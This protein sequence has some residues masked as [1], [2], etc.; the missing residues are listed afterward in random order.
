MN[1]SV[2][3]LETG[4]T[5]RGFE[6]FGREAQVPVAQPVEHPALIVRHELQHHQ[7]SPGLEQ[8]PGLGQH[9]GGGLHVVQALGD[10]D[11]IPL[12]GRQR[13]AVQV[14][15]QELDV[16]AALARGP[17]LRLRERLRVLID[18]PHP[19]GPAGNGHREGAGATT[20]VRHIEGRQQR[21]QRA[22]PQGPGLA[23]LEQP[24][25]ERLP[26]LPGAEQILQ[27]GGVSRVVLGLLRQADE[28]PAAVGLLQGEGVV[29]EARLPLLADKAQPLELAQVVGHRGLG[30]AHQGH[31]FRHVQRSLGHEA[32]DPQPCRVSKDA[33]GLGEDIHIGEST[34]ID[35]RDDTT[36]IRDAARCPPG[37]TR[38]CGRHGLP[39]LAPTPRRQTHRARP[40]RGL[41]R[42]LRSRRLPEGPGQRGA[43]AGGL[44]GHLGGRHGG[45]ARRGGHADSRDGGVAAEADAGE[46]LGSRP[47]GGGE[48]RAKG[49]WL[50]GPAQGPAVPDAAGGQP[51]GAH[52]RGVAAPAALGGREPHPGHAR[53]VH[54]GRAGTGHP[55]HLCLPGAVPL[56][57]HR[58]VALLGRRPGG[59]GACPGAERERDRQGPGRPPRALPPEQD[60]QG[61]GRPLGVR[62]GIGDGLLG[63]AARPLPASAEPVG[64]AE[65]ARV[66]RHLQPAP[67]DSD[68]PGARLRRHGSSP[69]VRGARPGAAAP[70]VRSLMSGGLSGS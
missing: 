21:G 14:L 19:A 51:A 23:R 22:R 63:P 27:P 67:C 37:D 70:E 65:G 46:L 56:G 59:Q 17:L 58:P 53:C 38:L 55:R 39:H 45:G 54:L 10:D 1:L 12:A 13:Q 43:P 8:P 31:Q 7:L 28:R 66:R 4:L 30:H 57:A 48:G 32:Q 42:F 62:P 49:A 68:H 3:E 44:R 41:F 61:G 35:S 69:A 52:L 15:A 9:R 26:V 18:G 24:L 36:R 20:E 47:A 34:Y 64:D 40:L 6:K 29:A 11:E 33:K 5:Q 50:H 25:V 60:A 16:G 2:E